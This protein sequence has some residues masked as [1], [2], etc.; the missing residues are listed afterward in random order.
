MTKLTFYGLRAVLMMAAF[1]V[2]PLARAADPDPA[3]TFDSGDIAT[4]EATTITPSTGPS[5]TVLPAMIPNFGTF[6]AGLGG[7]AP[8]TSILRVSNNSSAA[9]TVAFTLYDAATGAQ[10][11]AFTSA[12]IP[13]HG[14][15]QITATQIIAGA[16]PTLTATQKA[17]VFNAVAT[18]SF[19]GGSIQ[20]LSRTSASL[21]TING[22]PS[23]DAGAYGY[24]EG[25]GFTGLTGVLRL[26]N[27]GS[28]ASTVTLAI[29]D[30]AT[31]TQIATWKSPSVPAKGLYAITSTALAAAATPPVPAA[32]VAL[33]LAPTGFGGRLTSQHLAMVTGT[34]AL[35]DL[36]D[37]CGLT[38]PPIFFGPIKR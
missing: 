19:H 38:G 12:S 17:A 2:S 15:I 24:F 34:T 35:A 7:A 16:T 30:A 4:A 14:A 37:A 31:G 22:C 33:M 5:A 6:V 9:G 23:G 29:R 1:A 20:Q 18:A 21:S 25:P 26:I 3:A 36:G 8:D 13:A 10:E 32:T 11:G 28:A 27:S